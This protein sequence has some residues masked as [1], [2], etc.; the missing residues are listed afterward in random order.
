VCARVCVRACARVPVRVRVGEQARRYTNQLDVRAGRIH[1]TQLRVPRRS[2]NTH[3][4]ERLHV[5]KARVHTD[6]TRI[7]QQ[8]SSTLLRPSFSQ[9]NSCLSTS[10]HPPVAGSA[11]AGGAGGAEGQEGQER[12][13]GQ[14]GQEGQEEQRQFPAI[15]PPLQSSFA[16]GTC[17]PESALCTHR[18]AASCF[19]LPLN[20]PL[21]SP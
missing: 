15:I 8:D 19:S 4:G 21:F 17:R 16:S 10:P 14:E 11:R 18:L 1:S 3:T 20:I 5:K 9:H 12:Q 13:E 2:A 7:C 6:E